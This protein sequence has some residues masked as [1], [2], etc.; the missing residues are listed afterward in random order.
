MQQMLMM[1]CMIIGSVFIFI[2]ALG[3]LR[4][5]DLYM[6]LSA[7]TKAST[8]GIGFSL[9][10][11]ALHFNELGI[12]SRALATIAFVAVSSPVAA[13]L[14]GRSAY[15]TG[16]PLW[17]GSKI[18]ELKSQKAGNMKSLTDDGVL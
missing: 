4:L 15:H 6:R 3:I 2:A 18:D 13:H 9:L 1:M 17:K 7:A 16:A 5:P 11:L 12:T 10:A 8:L 14:I